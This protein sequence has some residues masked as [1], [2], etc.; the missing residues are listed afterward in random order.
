VILKRWWC[1]QS[2]LLPKEG[3]RIAIDMDEMKDPLTTSQR[4]QGCCLK[5]DDVTVNMSDLISFEVLLLQTYHEK[6]KMQSK[7]YNFPHILL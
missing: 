2:G 4:Q 7:I 5:F 1:P 6:L 3:Y